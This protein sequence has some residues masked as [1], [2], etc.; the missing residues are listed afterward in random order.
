MPWITN[1]TKKKINLKIR[2]LVHKF[3][4]SRHHLKYQFNE[5]FSSQQMNSYSDNKF[6]E[7]DF[8]I[9]LAKTCFM[10]LFI[11]SLYS[12]A[13]FCNILNHNIHNELNGLRKKMNLAK[14]HP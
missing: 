13:V 3:L 6:T 2:Q 9:R 11:F 10:N 4:K 12:W 14:S 1:K 7:K 5:I 8:S